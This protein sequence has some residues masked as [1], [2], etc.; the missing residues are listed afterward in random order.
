MR[1]EMEFNM[2][3]TQQMH[4]WFVYLTELLCVLIISGTDVVINRKQ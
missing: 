3:L 4:L 1:L 2:F